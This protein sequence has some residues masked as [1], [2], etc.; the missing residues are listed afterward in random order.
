MPCSSI[1][2]FRHVRLLQAL[3]CSGTA[4][5]RHIHDL[6][7]IIPFSTAFNWTYM[8]FLAQAAV[9]CSKSL[10]KPVSLATSCRDPSHFS[11]AEE[12][13]K[14]PER[15]F[16]IGIGNLA[17]ACFCCSCFDDHL[18]QGQISRK[19]IRTSAGF[20]VE[21]SLC[22]IIDG[23]F[24]PPI[25]VIG[26]LLIVMRHRIRYKC[27]D[28]LCHSSWKPLQ[29]LLTKAPDANL[30]LRIALVAWPHSAFPLATTR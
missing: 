13:N 9:T 18:G 28:N 4:L 12:F 23:I 1:A 3:P 22:V 30:S 19:N 24:S 16:P 7:Y 6:L 20:C 25:V 15:P 2:L 21:C 10:P 29:Q 27:C 8:H 26:N 11:A 14:I 17:V 5:C